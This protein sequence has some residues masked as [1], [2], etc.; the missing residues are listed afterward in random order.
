MKDLETT[1]IIYLH[2]EYKKFQIIGRGVDDLKTSQIYFFR[3]SG[4][5]LC[6]LIAIRHD[7]RH[8]L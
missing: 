2:R 1:F 6:E 8:S 4:S 5:L 3:S 7:D